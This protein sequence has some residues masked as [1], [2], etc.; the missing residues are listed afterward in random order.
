MIFIFPL[1]PTSC[2]G[3]EIA[4]YIIKLLWHIV[5][6]HGVSVCVCVCVWHLL[7]LLM[8]EINISKLISHA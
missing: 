3:P 2:A 5:W 1:T 8:Q 4:N 6:V 7:D